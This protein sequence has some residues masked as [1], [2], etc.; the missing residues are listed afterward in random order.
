[1]SYLVFPAS[2][3]WK[4]TG[5]VQSWPQR[6]VQNG[7]AQALLGTD[8]GGV[9]RVFLGTKPS[10]SSRCGLIMFYPIFGAVGMTWPP[11]EGGR[12][13]RQ[14]AAR[15]TQW[16]PRGNPSEAPIW[17]RNSMDCRWVDVAFDIFTHAKKECPGATLTVTLT[18][19][20]KTGGTLVQDGT[21]IACYSH[22]CG[23]GMKCL[24]Q[25]AGYIICHLT[26]FFSHLQVVMG[27]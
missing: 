27:P 24:L 5:G 9:F 13:S 20:C 8:V 11:R 23:H 2:C 10:K 25:L 26:V 18:L 12:A 22:S 21:V 1:M 3:S 4:K 7:S 16:M 15:P 14:E 6:G 19:E 17:C